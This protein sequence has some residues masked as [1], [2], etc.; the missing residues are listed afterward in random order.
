MSENEETK[1][2]QELVGLFSYIKRVRK[3]IASINHPAEPDYQ[4]GT[5]AEQLDEIVGATEEATDEIMTTIEKNEELIAKVRESVTDKAVLGLLDQVTE[6][7]MSVFEA[8]SFQDITGQRVSKVLKSIR[9][10]EDRITAIVN[11]WGK[12]Q[13]SGINVEAIEKTEDEA[14]LHGPQLKNE[15]ISQDEID[16]LFD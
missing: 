9:Y 16:K 10:V 12:D 1:L 8:C 2:K 15:G 3:E 5:M 4:F 14:L 13:I 7:N 6:N 11:I